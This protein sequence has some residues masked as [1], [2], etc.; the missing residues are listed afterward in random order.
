M[1]CGVLVCGMLL[2]A[3]C[4][5]LRCDVKCGGV[6][7]WNVIRCG[8]VMRCGICCG[9][10]YAVTLNVGVV[11]KLAMWNGVRCGLRLCDVEHVLRDVVV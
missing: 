6:E 2:N 1:E 11:W 4:G 3:K 5:K 8:G 7:L 9:V 10:K